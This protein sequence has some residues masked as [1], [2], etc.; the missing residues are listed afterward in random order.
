MRRGIALDGLIDINLCQLSGKV[1]CLK[2]AN[3][4]VYSVLFY[5]KSFIL[6][7]HINP[8]I[9]HADH[10]VWFACINYC[11][12][13]WSPKGKQ[14]VVGKADGTLV[15]YDQRLAEKKCVPAAVGLFNNGRNVSGT[16]FLGKLFFEGL[17]SACIVFF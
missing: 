1:G 2:L 6:E 17:S 3:V 8:S 9:L 15:Q 14:I 13:C 7:V 10:R 4:T 11:L 12:V 5:S 16:Q